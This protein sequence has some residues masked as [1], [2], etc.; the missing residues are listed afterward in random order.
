MIVMLDVKI[1]A[2]SEPT[3]QKLYYE[4]GSTLKNE[5]IETWSNT[6]NL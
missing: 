6:Q 5:K 4:I 2:A 1:K 3:S